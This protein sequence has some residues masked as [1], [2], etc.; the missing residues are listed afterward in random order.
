MTQT[1]RAS[2]PSP[3]ARWPFFVAGAVAVAVA[4]A[5]GEIVAGLV[6]GAPS[7]V[8]S[9]GS[10]AIDLQPP[11]AKDVVV[12]LFG[13]N[14]KLALNVLSALFRVAGGTIFGKSLGETLRRI[15]ASPA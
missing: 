7:L 8:V 14:D 3:A 11:G 4:I 15:E 2:P 6:S 10:L 1:D 9:V 5:V 13:T 12:S